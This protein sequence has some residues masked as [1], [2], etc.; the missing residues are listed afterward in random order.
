MQVQ[1]K[2]EEDVLMNEQSISELSQPRWAV[3]SFESVAVRNLSYDEAK[4]WVEKLEKQ[5]VSGLCIVTDEA[6]ARME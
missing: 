3:V 6:A 4:I 2:P 5:N 1:T